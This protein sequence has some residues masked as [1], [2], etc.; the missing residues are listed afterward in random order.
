MNKKLISGVAT[1]LLGL[2]GFLFAGAS[3]AITPWIVKY[4]GSANAGDEANLIATDSAGNIYVS[5]RSESSALFIAPDF[6][7]VKYDASGNQ[8]WVQRYG[9]G[10][11][12]IPVAIAVDALDN[13]YVTGNSQVAANGANGIVTIKYDNNG[14]VVWTRRFDVPDNNSVSSMTVDRSGNVYL[15]GAILN[16]ATSVFNDFVSQP[17]F[18]V[19]VFKY[20]ANGNQVWERRY[21][22]PG[23]RSSYL[24][25]IGRKI[26][27]DGSGQ[28]YVGGTSEGFSLNDFLTLKYTA[29]GSLLWASRYAGSLK[30]E[31][32]DL[33]VDGGGNVYVTGGSEGSYPNPIPNDFA[34]LVTSFDYATIKYDANGNQLWVQRYDGPTSGQDIPRS[35]AVDNGGNVYVSGDSFNSP[36]ADIAILKY[37][38]NG[39]R[40]WERRYRGLDNDFAAGGYMAFDPKGFIYATGYSHRTSAVYNEFDYATVKFDTAGN[41][42]AAQHYN[43]PVNGNDVASAIAIDT[44]GNVYV[45]GSS[46][47]GNTTNGDYATIKFTD[48]N[49]GDFSVPPPQ[50]QIAFPAIA[51][52]KGVLISGGYSNWQ[53][54]D[55]TYA[56]FK[57]TSNS[58]AIQLTLESTLP[59]KTISALSFTLEA[60]VTTSG[61]SQKVELYNFT[62]QVYEQ[63]DVRTAT[64]RDS[65]VTVSAA[66][67]LTRFV[68]ASDKLLRTRLT[69]MPGS[70][71]AKW[72]MSMDQAIWTVTP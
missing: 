69:W 55:N 25:D 51:I 12:D 13:I 26:V 8:L 64:R 63:V 2:G 6:A 50:P 61:I 20:D 27:V 60:A 9:N 38:N 14:N 22:A 29:D 56:N 66:G 47:S 70:G 18:D 52:T 49:I 1:V 53:Y 15:N 3:Q 44:I 36:G 42:L 33:A 24:S 10:G 46:Y 31:V 65:Q 19:L 11:F 45:T 17:D 67:D 54:S 39:N 23:F 71:A 41:L 7:T 35:I 32:V 4:N 57:P 72:S 43:G 40:I 58:E 21:N 5:G 62:N 59:T 68:Q 37:D 16:P 28:V 34:P 48:G 30:D